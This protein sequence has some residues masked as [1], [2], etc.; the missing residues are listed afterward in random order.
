MALICFR[1]HQHPVI[2][3]IISSKTCNGHKH[4]SAFTC[5]QIYNAKKS[6]ITNNLSLY[7]QRWLW[8]RMFKKCSNLM[9]KEHYSVKFVLVFLFK[10]TMYNFSGKCTWVI[11]VLLTISNH[12]NNSTSNNQLIHGTASNHSH[13]KGPPTPTFPPKILLQSSIKR[14]NS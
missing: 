1:I 2:T 13:V 12:N 6:K 4:K 5:L 7:Q 11:T 10:S 14:S 8:S 3:R 9:T